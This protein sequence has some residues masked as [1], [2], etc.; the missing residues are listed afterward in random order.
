MDLEILF[1]GGISTRRHTIDREY[2]QERKDASDEIKSNGSLHDR[3]SQYLPQTT[4][5]H[6][7]M[8]HDEEKYFNEETTGLNMSKTHLGR[9]V[10]SICPSYFANEHETTCLNINQI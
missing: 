9:N 3:E 4:P 8:D 6:L 5:E 10:V 1:N 2:I 7:F